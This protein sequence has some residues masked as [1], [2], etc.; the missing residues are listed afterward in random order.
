MTMEFSFATYSK[1][2]FLP[3]FCIVGIL[4]RKPFTQNRC[5]QYYWSCKYQFASL[6]IW[7]RL[8]YNII[9]RNT[10]NNYLFKP[11]K[12][13]SGLIHSMVCYETIFLCH[14]VNYLIH[15]MNWVL[16]KYNNC[17]MSREYNVECTPDIFISYCI[18]KKGICKSFS[19]HLVIIADKL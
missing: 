18:L 11:N 13:S 12:Y 1:V 7:I 16:H 6:S 14:L 9:E 10:L 17:H 8:I 5:I 15:K 3:I 2:F 19:R 4:N